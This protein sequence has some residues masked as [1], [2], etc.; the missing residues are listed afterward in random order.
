MNI[1]LAVAAILSAAVALLIAL[2]GLLRWVYRR[3][4]SSGAEKARREADE[5]SQA[6][7]K[8]RIKDLERVLAETRAELASIQP[9]RKR[10]LQLRG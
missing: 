8:A 4:E 5:R 10:G 1:A 6:E 7:D 2:A 3:G 9:K